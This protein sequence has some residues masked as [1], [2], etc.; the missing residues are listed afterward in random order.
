MRHHSLAL[1]CVVAVVLNL[2]LPNLPALAAGPPTALAAGSISRAT[3]RDAAPTP[4]PEPD[5]V[6]VAV[7]ALAALAASRPTGGRRGR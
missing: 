4:V 3:A 1:S 2:A 5:G 7:I 6:W